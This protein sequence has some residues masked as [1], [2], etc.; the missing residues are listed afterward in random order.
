[1]SVYKQLTTADTIVTP[2]EVNKSFT[3]QGKN[4]FSS[5]NVNID[6]LIGT[7]PTQSLFNSS[8]FSTT[9]LYNNQFQ[10]LVYE[11]IEHLYYSNYLSQS[12]GDTA[13]TASF[14]NDG[15]ITGIRQTTNNY[16]Y[17]TN[18]L[19]QSRELLPDGGTNIGVLTIPRSLFGEYIKP[20]SFIFN[21]GVHRF[22]DDKQGNIFTTQ[23]TG[24]THVGNIIYE[25]GVIV[26]TYKLLSTGSFPPDTQGISESFSRQNLTCSFDSTKT[27][28]ETQFLCNLNEAEYNFSLNPTIISKPD[29]TVYPYTTGSW[30]NP[31]ITTVGLYNNNLDLIANENF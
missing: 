1:M 6:L 7:L 5:S 3:F 11:S 27:I 20:G 31:Y 15:T 28:Y 14:N 4:N 24:I 21:D 9:G 12:Y 18:T 23:N 22:T 30:F 19:T 29:G 26:F 2:F 8:S 25:H 16:N 17:L 13:A 10:D